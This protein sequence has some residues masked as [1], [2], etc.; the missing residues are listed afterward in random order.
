M[1]YR[2]QSCKIEF[3]SKAE[4]ELH[5]V[6]S[7][8]TSG[9]RCHVYN[10]AEN[11]MDIAENLAQDIHNSTGGWPDR[12]LILSALEEAEEH[13]LAKIGIELDT[14]AKNGVHIVRCCEGGGPENIVASVVQ[15]IAALNYRT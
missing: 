10:I 15:T 13:G 2:C 5:C 9:P 8:Q 1:R 7:Y 11:L 3:K 6:A 14:M 12:A 4:G